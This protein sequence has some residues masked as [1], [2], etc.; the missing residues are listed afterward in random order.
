MYLETVDKLI[1]LGHGNK[2]SLDCVIFGKFTSLPQN[3]FERAAVTQKLFPKTGT[4]PVIL[5]RLDDRHH[6]INHPLPSP[7][8]LELAINPD[9]EF[10]IKMSHL[11]GDAISMIL[12]LQAF[13]GVETKEI[14][15]D[16]QLKKFP[17]KKRDTPFRKIIP[18]YAWPRSPKNISRER[19]FIFKQ[20]EHSKS[21][22]H[23][24]N[25]VFILS[26]LK[27]LPQEEPSLWLPV[28][29]RESFFQG[30]GNGLS[31]MRIYPPKEKTLE[32]Q[33]LNIRYQKTQNLM[34]GEV[35]L[36]PKNLKIDGFFQQKLIS[37]WL[38][39]PWADW[40]SLSFSHLTDKNDFLQEMENI[41][42]VSN[43][44]PKHNAAIFALTKNQK[45]N[46]CMSYDP[47]QMSRSEGEKLISDMIQQSQEMIYEIMA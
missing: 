41:W 13:I 23:K 44:M 32:Q 8:H 12:W 42:G 7:F 25:D 47:S 36:P 31:R 16:L 9:G 27:S 18:T 45:T 22:L 1:E 28:N 17:T 43:I 15:S 33:L 6:F 29:A 10:G 35:S 26:L 2:R 20:I 30:F 24:L 19:D 46:F 5:T 38:E 4:H 37:L 39:R 14:K 21:T 11:L 3:I 40:G 34:N